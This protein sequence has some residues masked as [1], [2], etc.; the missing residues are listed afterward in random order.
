MAQNVNPAEASS[1]S[2]PEEQKPEGQH[3]GAG[4][5]NGQHVRTRITFLEMI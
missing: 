4:A 5:N 3:A 1:M 2:D